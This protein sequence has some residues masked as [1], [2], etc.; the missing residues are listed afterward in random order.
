MLLANADAVCAAASPLV[1]SQ[2]IPLD[3]FEEKCIMNNYFGIGLDAKISLDFNQ[4]RD[5]HPQ[6][7]RSRTRNL[8]FYGMLGGKEIVAKTFK[9]L[10]QRIRL[11]CD[12]RLVSLPNL[13]GIVILNIPSYM[14]GTNFWGTRDDDNFVTPSFD[15]KIL[16]VVAVFNSVQL[17]VSRVFNLQKHRIAQCRSLTITILGD[18]GVPVHVDGEAWIQPPSVIKIVHRNR[19]QM[20]TRDKVFEEALKT[21]REKQSLEFPVGCHHDDTLSDA[22]TAILMSFIDATNSL[23][24]SVKLAALQCSIVEHELL[25][26]AVQA[27]EFLDRLYPH[28]QLTKVTY[29]GQVCDLVN[30]VRTLY[31]ETKSLLLKEASSLPLSPDA[32]QCLLSSVATMEVVMTKMYKIGGLP[33]FQM[34]NNEVPELAAK[35]KN[36]SRWHSQK[37]NRK[38]KLPGNSCPLS[39]TDWSTNHVSQW[40]HAQGFDEY[41]DT[42]VTNDIRGQELITLSRADLRDLGINKVGHVKRI[43][44]AIKELKE[45]SIVPESLSETDSHDVITQF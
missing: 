9:N 18:E 42:F 24:K 32:A 44:H 16:E 15:D 1:E 25:H 31:T 17:G 27:T 39:V 4:R 5:D 8:M 11:E 23:L 12:G 20:L 14:G 40:L 45:S 21:W 7:C 13:Q 2:H 30:G 33:H 41:R 22:E 34:D 38:E 10:E 36:S 29:R 35:Q 19:A 37:T 26:L 43:R 6:R 28:G 3:Q